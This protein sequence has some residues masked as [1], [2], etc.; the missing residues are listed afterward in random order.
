MLLY[1]TILLLLPAWL[2]GYH[3]LMQRMDFD[4]DEPGNW[5]KEK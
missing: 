4:L 5:D 1:F 2:P 3:L